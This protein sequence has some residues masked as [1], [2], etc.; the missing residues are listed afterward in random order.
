MYLSWVPLA[1]GV[2]SDAV[3]PRAEA[4]VSS[5]GSTEVASVSKLIHAVASRPQTLGSGDSPQDCRIQLDSLRI[6]EP[7]RENKPPTKKA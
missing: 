1:Q 5:E 4:V 6:Q 3:K 7:G 2:S